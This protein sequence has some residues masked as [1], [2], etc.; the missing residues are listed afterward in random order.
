MLH[1][2]LSY[3][4]LDRLLPLSRS[5]ISETCFLLEK[6]RLLRREDECWMIS[7]PAYPLVRTYLKENDYLLDPF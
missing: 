4:L 2:S 5:G 7:P 3:D 1:G 6:A